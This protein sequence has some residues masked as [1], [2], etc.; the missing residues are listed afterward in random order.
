MTVSAARLGLFNF[1]HFRRMFSP[2]SQLCVYG[3]LMNEL[4]LIR[5]G[6]AAELSKQKHEKT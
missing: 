1:R 6:C 4:L 2:K 5:H 3:L